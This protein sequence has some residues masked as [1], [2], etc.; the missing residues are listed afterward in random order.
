MALKING[1]R[2]AGV[3]ANGRDGA[4]VIPGGKSGQIL[5]KRS[6]ADHDTVW[7]DLPS[8]DA[9]LSQKGQAADAKAVGDQINTINNI[10]SEG[11]ESTLSS[12]KN[13]TD[14]QIA[15][16]VNSAPET[17]DTLGE[18]AIAFNENKEVV[19]ALNE[20]IVLKANKS[21]VDD[22][23]NTKANI[24][25][26]RF[27]GS[28]GMNHTGEL[29]WTSVS[30]GFANT[31]S[32]MYCF[33]E[34]MGN[35]STGDSSHSEGTGNTASGMASHAEGSGVL[36]SGVGAHAEGA[37]TKATGYGSHAEGSN[38]IASIEGQHVEGKYNIEDA[39][40]IHIVGNGTSDK[41]RSNAHTLS[42]NGDAWFAGDITVGENKASVIT[43]EDSIIF[44]GGTATIFI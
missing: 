34:G 16:L 15:D 7:T 26:P 1:V 10:V 32:G 31:A 19:D 25:E 40:A 20:A 42:L 35:K 23:L 2:V 5:S 24:E 43:E 12:A 14:E 21:Y 28:M 29:G 39:T 17:L 37:N 4:G 9:T 44:S 36:A 18:L 22:S 3:G 38:T 41:Q 8:I 11:D 27:S 6:D 30:L 33:A 13:Y